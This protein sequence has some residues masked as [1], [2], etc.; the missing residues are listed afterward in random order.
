MSSKVIQ[1][2]F[3]DVVKMNVNDINAASSLLTTDEVLAFLKVKS[4]TVYRL[5]KT[6][7]LPAIR[8]GRRWRVRRGDLEAWL[9]GKRPSAA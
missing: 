3:I 6:G 9:D 7:D 8:V 4:C 1:T 5:I 2:A